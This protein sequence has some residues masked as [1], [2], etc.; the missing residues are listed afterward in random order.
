[1]MGCRGKMSGMK[2]SVVSVDLVE[3]G[4]IVNFGDGLGAFFPTEFFYDHRFDKGIR[5][6]PNDEVGEKG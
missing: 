4:V 5:L 1:M 2:P 3:S 6:L